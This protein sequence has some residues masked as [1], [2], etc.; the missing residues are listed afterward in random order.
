M[1]SILRSGDTKAGGKELET[2]LFVFP[3]FVLVG[4]RLR[5]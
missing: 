3:C 5:W 1:S 2:E 4:F